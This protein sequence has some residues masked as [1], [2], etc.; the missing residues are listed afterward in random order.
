[1]KTSTLVLLLF[2][3]ACQ[4]EHTPVHVVNTDSHNK[5]DPIK[6]ADSVEMA[7]DTSVYYNYMIPLS[8]KD[9][10]CMM[11][12]DSATA[13]VPIDSLTDDNRWA[14][15]NAVRKKIPADILKVHKWFGRCR[16][17]GPLLVEMAK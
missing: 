5:V 10:T 4:H 9:S 3:S 8:E 16:K 17:C 6:R 12:I 14:Y 7:I 15:Y 2:L 1:M 13:Y 11:Y